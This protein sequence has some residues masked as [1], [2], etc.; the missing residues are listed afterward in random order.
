MP[1]SAYVIADASTG[2]VLAAKDPHGQ[3]ALASTL[4]LPTAV[5]P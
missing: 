2:Q 5:T 3:F 1:A 4:K